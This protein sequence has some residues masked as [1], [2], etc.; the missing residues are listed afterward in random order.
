MFYGNCYE[1]ETLANS[2]GTDMPEFLVRSVWR[3][4]I[5]E[6]PQ[7]AL[8]AGRAQPGERVSIFLPDFSFW[9][10]FSQMTDINYGFYIGRNQEISVATGKRTNKKLLWAGRKSPGSSSADY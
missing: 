8:V 2:V 9:C 6:I 5:G 3:N 10:P 7:H 1:Y 4:L